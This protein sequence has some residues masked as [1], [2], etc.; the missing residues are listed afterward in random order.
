MHVPLD[1]EIMT[2]SP[3][4]TVS[5]YEALAEVLSKPTES[6][7]FSN[8]KS[9]DRT[10]LS[11]TPLLSTTTSTTTTTTTSTTTPPP[12]TTTEAVKDSKVETTTPDDTYQSVNTVVVNNLE[13]SADASTMGIDLQLTTIS[14]PPPESRFPDSLT[15]IN[16]LTS[17]TNNQ[18][19]DLGNDSTT[20]LIVTR[21][22]TEFTDKRQSNE[23]SSSESYQTAVSADTRVRTDTK[24]KTNSTDNLYQTKLLSRVIRE[25]TEAFTFETETLAQIHYEANAFNRIEIETIRPNQTFSKHLPENI[26]GNNFM[27]ALTSTV[28][29][30][31]SP[32]FSPANRIP[33]LSFGV[34]NERNVDS[35]VKSKKIELMTKKITKSD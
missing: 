14:L 32:R 8:S 24:Q 7:N 12:P 27:K 30:N 2:Q 6:L 15:M 34:N 26:A 35:S 11:E 20:Q 1:G 31:Y 9:T 16:N 29:S 28:P 3:S 5:I 19:N 21:L 13:M 18:T 23:A 17:L 33:I 4:Q 25:T 10:L 22:T